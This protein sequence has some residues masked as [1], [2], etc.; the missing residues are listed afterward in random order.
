M[1]SLSLKQKNILDRILWS[2][3]GVLGFVAGN[4]P[5][6]AS[7]FS[8]AHQALVTAVAT[9]VGVLGGDVVSDLIAFVDTGTVPVGST[10]TTAGIAK[11]WT[12][13]KAIAQT[14]I[15]KLP[16]SDQAIANALVAA[17]DAKFAAGAPAS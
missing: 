13:A 9:G 6:I 10:T 15:A 3:G 7:A 12:D 11:T 8:P 4:V 2:L 5:A 16:A 14:E 1:V 17:L